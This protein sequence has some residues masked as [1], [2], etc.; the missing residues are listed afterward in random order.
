MF[1]DRD[2]YFS[3]CDSYD[4]RLVILDL[5]VFKNVGNAL[6]LTRRD[7]WKRED[8]TILAAVESFWKECEGGW[9]SRRL[10]CSP[11]H[12]AVPLASLARKLGGSGSVLSPG[13][14]HLHEE[15]LETFLNSFRTF[16]RDSGNGFAKISEDLIILDESY[17]FGENTMTKSRIQSSLSSLRKQ[18]FTTKNVKLSDTFSNM[19]FWSVLETNLE[20][21]G[22]FGKVRSYFGDLKNS[23][24]R[25][26]TK[27]PLKCCTG[28][29]EYS[30]RDVERFKEILWGS[31]RS[32]EAATVTDK[33]EA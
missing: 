24:N 1:P 11:L 21:G 23:K 10:Y 32:F 7:Q 33:A 28:S 16:K 5:P 26:G 6:T 25:F 30:R 19:E 17:S 14:T 13:W 9:S 8:A 18:P 15:R 3:S 4:F 2:Q 22:S 20:D 12:L 31:G 27:E 29:Q